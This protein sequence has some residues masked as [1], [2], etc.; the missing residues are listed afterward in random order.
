MKKTT[1]RMLIFFV[2]LV[3]QVL[4]IMYALNHPEGSFPISV[5]LTDALYIIYE[6][7]ML[8]MPIMCIIDKI[9]SSKKK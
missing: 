6:V 3:I 4:F 8:S 2:M 1:K 7:V 9:K 5:E